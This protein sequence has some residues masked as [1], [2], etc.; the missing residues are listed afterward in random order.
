MSGLAKGRGEMLSPFEA[1]L[2]GILADAPASRYDVMKVIQS[3]SLYWAGSP[4]AVYSALDRLV[5]RGMIQEVEGSDP[6]QYK[7]T[8][9]GFQS[10]YQFLTTP[11]P[12]AK[13][14]VDQ[15]LVRLKL[16]GIKEFSPPDQVE[17]F[18]RQLEEYPKA[19]KMIQEKR[20]GRFERPICRDLV[21]LAI[22][23]LT[24]EE[25]LIKKLLADAVEE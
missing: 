22:A 8:A 14:I 25:N 18:Q 13:L 11:V 23:Q 15:S 19:V 6:K 12:A 5:N 4:G 20:G 21:E 16:R 24:L 9:I 10:G 2:I 17:F 1:T 3:Q 7:V